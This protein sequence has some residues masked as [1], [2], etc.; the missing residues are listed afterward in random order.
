V[1]R[2][3]GG[4]AGGFSGLRGCKPAAPQPPRRTHLG[5]DH[6][7][8]PGLHQHCDGLHQAVEWVEDLPKKHVPVVVL[9]GEVEEL[10]AGRGCRGKGAGRH[11]GRVSTALRRPE[12]R[13]SQRCT[14]QCHGQA[15]GDADSEVDPPKAHQ[16]RGSRLLSREGSL[17]ARLTSITEYRTRGARGTSV[18]VL[19]MSPLV[20]GSSVN[21]LYLWRSGR[22]M[23]AVQGLIYEV[24]AQSGRN[25]AHAWSAAAR[26]VWA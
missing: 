24:Q 26:G 17:P 21:A 14:A 18:I 1:L 8:G 19:P 9:P 7:A 15:T 11:V 13:G 4:R 12:G 20:A 6:P 10:M 25:H 23:I 5:H 22:Q 3:G 2:G 16:E